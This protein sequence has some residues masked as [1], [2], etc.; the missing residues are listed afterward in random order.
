MSEVSPIG[1]VRSLVRT[2]VVRERLSKAK[3]SAVGQA[4]GKSDSW[5]QKALDDGMGVPIDLIEPLLAFLGLRIVNAD[6]CVVRREVFD[7]Y[8]ALATAALVDPG[9]LSLREK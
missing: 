5:A 3:Q 4:L 2:G 7:S 9:T 1:A 8:K 6:E